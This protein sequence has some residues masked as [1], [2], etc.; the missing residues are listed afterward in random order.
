MKILG[1]CGSPRSQSV[2]ST[3]RVVEAVLDA[4]GLSFELVS[5]RGMKI[6]G[7]IA[8]LGC[9]HDNVCVINDSMAELREKIVNADAFVIGA[10]N[11]YSAINATTASM[12]ERWFQFRHRT[13]D[14]LWGRLA[15]AVGVGGGQGDSASEQIER[16]LS[17]N[18]IETVAKVNAQGAASC[19]RC[20]YGESCK[21][22]VPYMLYGEGVQITDDMIPD[23]S[24]QPQV[25]QAARQAG[26][27]LAERLK[28]HDRRKVAGMMQQKMMEHFKQ[29]V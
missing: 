27:L 10:P 1:I 19:F 3:Y 14:T 29:S 17:Y 12:L 13:A 18:F 25:L 6:N 23:V 22:G 5:L 9:V 2:S 15:V 24:K 20:G 26:K 21:V 7:C 11:Y 8:C 28:T 16:Y 4:T